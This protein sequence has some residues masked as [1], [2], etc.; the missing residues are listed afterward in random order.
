M[1]LRA[2]RVVNDSRSPVLSPIAHAKLAPRRGWRYDGGVLVFSTSAYEVLVARVRA[3]G[4]FPAGEV[5]RTH[6]PDGEVYQRVVSVVAGEDVAIVG[7]TP[8]DQA[9]LEL[10]DLASGLVE[11]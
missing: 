9:A 5:E 11:C 7:G 1:R 8:T 2:T 3:H 4:H 10:Y 6:F